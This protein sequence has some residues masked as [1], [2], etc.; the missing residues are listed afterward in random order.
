M[1]ALQRPSLD[2]HSS[3]IL[4]E[5][6]G[7]VR[8]TLRARLLGCVV[9]GVFALTCGD[10]MRAAAQQKIPQQALIHRP[11]SATAKVAMVGGVAT[12]TAYIVATPRP[13]WSAP[14]H[15]GDVIRYD[16]AFANNGPAQAALV[17]VA[18]DRKS[19]V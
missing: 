5:G 19:V 13:L 1:S 11:I 15:A 12:P 16:V 2:A 9:G 10:A 4:V 3:G 8:T 18:Q 7:A 17:G 14:S 6:A